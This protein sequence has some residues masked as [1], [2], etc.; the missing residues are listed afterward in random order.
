MKLNAPSQTFW[1][2]AVVLG[3]VGI[4]GKLAIIPA[5]II[6][7]NAFWLVTIGFAILALTTMFKGA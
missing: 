3:V 2:I 4:L 7:G 6:A 5:A 1:L